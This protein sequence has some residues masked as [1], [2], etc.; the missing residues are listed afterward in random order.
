M[1]LG[2]VI[3]G[4]GGLPAALRSVI[5]Q[6]IGVQTALECISYMIGDDMDRLRSSI[7]AAITQV[8]SGKGV[9]MVTDMFGGAPSNVAISVGQGKNVEVISGMNL[10]M[11]LKLLTSRDLLSAKECVTE[12]R[13]MGQKNI[14]VLSELLGLVDTDY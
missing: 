4:H 7:A 6:M 9:V 12:A 14:Y 10:P 1:V 11:L 8:D 2:V 5:E 3:V 13:N